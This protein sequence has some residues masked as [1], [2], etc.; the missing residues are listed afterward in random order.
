MLNCLGFSETGAIGNSWCSSASEGFD[1]G[2][3]IDRGADNG[4]GGG[5]TPGKLETGGK[6]KFVNAGGGGKFK[7]AKEGGGGK[8]KFAK[9]EEVEDLAK[10]QVYNHFH[11]KQYSMGEVEAM[12]PSYQVKVEE[13]ILVILEHY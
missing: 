4:G 5:N 8:F 3:G 11:S 1:D 6:F 9:R 10:M 2:E 12:G 13:A 7:L